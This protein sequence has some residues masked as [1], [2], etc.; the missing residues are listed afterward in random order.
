MP[1]YD[2]MQEGADDDHLPAEPA[3]RP[4]QNLTKLVVHAPTDPGIVLTRQT[5]VALI[6]RYASV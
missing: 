4:R 3:R 6:A 1:S 5:V 2:V